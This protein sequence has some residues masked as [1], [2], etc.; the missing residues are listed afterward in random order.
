MLPRVLLAII[1]IFGKNCTRQSLIGGIFALIRD[2]GCEVILKS[3]NPKKVAGKKDISS[4]NFFC[5]Q[6]L[7]KYVL[8][9]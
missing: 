5:L 8:A 1:L 4:I 2:S 7:Q 6:K 3:V 9:L